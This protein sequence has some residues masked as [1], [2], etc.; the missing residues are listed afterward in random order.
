MLV[1]ALDPN[2]QISSPTEVDPGVVEIPST[3]PL[4]FDTPLWGSSLWQLLQDIKTAEIPLRG[5][6]AEYAGIY[7]NIGTTITSEW[8]ST[9]DNGVNPDLAQTGA[10]QPNKS[11]DKLTF[12]IMFR[13]PFQGEVVEVSPPLTD[14]EADLYNGC[15]Q[16]LMF[17]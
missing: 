2:A 3:M 11:L 17:W 4:G 14:P 13:M 10:S 16:L 5:K 9:S 1:L 6:I 7:T 15:G 8:D 12:L